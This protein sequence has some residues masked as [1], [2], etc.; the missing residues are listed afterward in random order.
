MCGVPVQCR[1]LGWGCCVSVWDSWSSLYCVM[2]N[3]PFW[4]IPDA[5][6]PQSTDAEFDTQAFPLFDCVCAGVVLARELEA[7]LDDLL[8]AAPW[9]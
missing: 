9:I 1:S 2:Y 4:A 3:V 6:V 8:G 5:P 7:A